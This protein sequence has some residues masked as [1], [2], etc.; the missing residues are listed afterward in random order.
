MQQWIKALSLVLGL[1]TC[2]GIADGFLSEWTMRAPCDDQHFLPSSMTDEGDDSRYPCTMFLEK[3]YLEENESF[4]FY[5]SSA[6]CRHPVFSTFLACLATVLL[7][8]AHVTF[9]WD[10]RHSAVYL[11]GVWEPRHGPVRELRVRWVDEQPEFSLF[12]WKRCNSC[13]RL[14]RVG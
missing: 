7:Y 1:S 8:L 4:M 11:P 13:H 5:L 3:I 14:K 2:I 9:K 10:H 6:A 12:E